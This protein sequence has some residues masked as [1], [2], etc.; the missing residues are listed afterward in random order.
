[1]HCIIH[2]EDLPKT[3]ILKLRPNQKEKVLEAK[4]YREYLVRLNRH[5]QQIETIP[6]TIN[7]RKHGIHRACYK[8]FVSIVWNSQRRDTSSTADFTESTTSQRRSSERLSSPDGAGSVRWFFPKDKCGICG[9]QTKRIHKRRDEG[10]DYLVLCEDPYV[11]EDIK[12][13]IRTRQPDLYAKI[14]SDDLIAHEFRYHSRCHLKFTRTRPATPVE[15]PQTPLLT[16]P[17]SPALTRSRSVTPVP[18]PSS[19][20]P[21]PATGQSLPSS[22][23]QQSRFVTPVPRSSPSASE[24][25]QILLSPPLPRTVIRVPRPSSSPPPPT[26]LAWRYY[27][28]GI[29]T[30]C[31]DRIACHWK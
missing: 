22:P 18:R 15:R 1:M 20:S 6:A 11:E 26:N 4:S 2:S 7:D 28:A 30:E 12:E 8:R 9:N 31:L 25:G 5:Q 14:G 23:L 3:T 13:Q 17:P 16:T 19:S 27:Y 21:P 10:R 24:T 29:D